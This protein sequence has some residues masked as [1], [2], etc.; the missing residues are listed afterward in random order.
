MESLVP[1]IIAIAFFIL[2]AVAAGNKKKEA[3]RR[4]LPRS[5]PTTVYAPRPVA[6][7]PKSPFE[8]LLE[9]MR[10]QG[11]IG[12][13]EEEAIEEETVVETPDEPEQNLYPAYQQVV[14]DE[15]PQPK[16]NN[17]AAAQATIASPVADEEHNA[18]AEKKK[19]THRFFT[20]PFDAGK[21]IVYSEIMRPKFAE[22]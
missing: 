16:A 11:A 8:Q 15:V 19:K 4:Q 13:I 21:A 1:V 17:R 6:S 22:A 5:E 9:A 12:D 2:Q 10:E 7:Q 20:E 3:A 14:L 18:F